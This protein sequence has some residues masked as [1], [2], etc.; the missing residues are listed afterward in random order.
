MG[1]KSSSSIVM[2]QGA[3][4]IPQPIP[5]APLISDNDN[6]GELS[7]TDEDVTSPQTVFHSN[8]GELSIKKKNRK[9]KTKKTN[10]SVNRLAALCLSDDDGDD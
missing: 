7:D 6:E 4:S 1:V 9:N 5:P 10:S 3:V 8:A 2:N